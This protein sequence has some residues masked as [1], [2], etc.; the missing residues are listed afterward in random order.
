MLLLAITLLFLIIIVKKLLLNLHQVLLWLYRLERNLLVI[1][2]QEVNF[3]WEMAGKVGLELMATLNVV[4]KRMLGYME[5]LLRKLF[6]DAAVYD[7]QHEV[8][9]GGSSARF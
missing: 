2:I 1:A 9:T 5:Y 7:A 4:I 3:Y 6:D 8:G